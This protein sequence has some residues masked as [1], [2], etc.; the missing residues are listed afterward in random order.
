MVRLQVAMLDSHRVLLPWDTTVG[1]RTISKV[2][3]VPPY[4][5][6][7]LQTPAITHIHM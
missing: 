4:P 6:S 3:S 7:Q 1:A 2:Q 5:R